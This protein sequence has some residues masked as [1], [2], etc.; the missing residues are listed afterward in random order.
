MVMS[1]SNPELQGRGQ[2]CAEYFDSNA[3]ALAS[4]TRDALSRK[5]LARYKKAKKTFKLYDGEMGNIVFPHLKNENTKF[6]DQVRKELKRSISDKKYTKA[7]YNPK[8]LF[9]T[10]EGFYGEDRKGIS[11]NKYVIQAVSL[12]A[13]LIKPEQWLDPALVSEDMDLMENLTTLNTSAGFKFYGKKKKHVSR[14][15][16]RESIR[17]WD[18]ISSGK[19]FFAIDVQPYIALTRC[20]IGSASV[21]LKYVRPVNDKGETKYK[22]RLVWCEDA[23]MVLFESIFARPLINYLAVHWDNISMGKSPEYLRDFAC[24][25]S[26]QMSVWFSNDYEKY[27][28]TVPAALIRL[29]FDIIKECF[30]PEYH[31]YI[32]FICTK[33]IHADIMMPDG[34]IYHVDR[35]IKSGSYFTQIIGSLCNAIM[36]FAFM[37]HKYDKI[38]EQR[39]ERNPNYYKFKM[40]DCFKLNDGRWACQ[41]M[42]DDNLF[43]VKG[44]FDLK[45]FRNYVNKVFGMKINLDKCARGKRGEPCDYLKRKWTRLGEIRDE[46]DL[47]VNLMHPERKRTYENYSPWHVLF[48]Y[49]MTYRRSMER[50][51]FS[52]YQIISGMKNSKY[53]IEAF[54]DMKREELPGAIAA[55]KYSNIEEFTHLVD[56]LIREAESEYMTIWED[57]A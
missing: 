2:S 4:E 41:F 35:G 29:A 20:Q 40:E 17:I 49:F 53:G 47:M 51:G 55:L 46:V 12:I 5:Y 48:G 14:Y 10:L 45:A 33:F 13:D 1:Y 42:G 32:D 54:Y 56:A 11:N 26:E 28:S 37:L 8:H 3:L 24:N 23:A 22:G 44:D 30:A 34:N 36:V 16:V 27:D 6:T 57:R 9:D 38:E 15:M 21:K 19:N 52:L 39:A 18:E 31:R 43:G 25:I 50:L 7:F